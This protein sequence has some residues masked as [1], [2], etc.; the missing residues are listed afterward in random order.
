MPRVKQKP[1][2]FFKAYKKPPVVAPG[3]FYMLTAKA[4][5]KPNLPGG[6]VPSW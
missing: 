6:C 1:R 4:I 5:W 2:A 3:D